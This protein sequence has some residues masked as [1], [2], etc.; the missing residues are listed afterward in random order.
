MFTPLSQYQW[1]VY[2]VVLHIFMLLA[3]KMFCSRPG[4]KG[5]FDAGGCFVQ[6]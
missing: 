2:T 3:S 5:G 6:R 4:G 1:Y